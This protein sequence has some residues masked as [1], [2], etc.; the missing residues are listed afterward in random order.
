MYIFCLHSRTEGF[1]NVLRVATAM[2]RPC[3][4][5][6]FGDAALLVAHTGLV[7]PKENA[8][9]LSA[10]LERLL[11]LPSAELHE[12]GQRARQ[13]IH[14]NFTTD[15]ARHQFEQVYHQLLREK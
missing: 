10:G 14:A 8:Q 5:T 3:V 15:H 1:S 9:V 12:L 7:V 2:A 11:S 6:D 13:R 4:V